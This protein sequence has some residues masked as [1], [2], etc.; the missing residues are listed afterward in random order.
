MAERSVHDEVDQIQSVGDRSPSDVPAAT[1][2]L[3]A[4]GVG[5]AENKTLEAVDNVTQEQPVTDDHAEGVE[6]LSK[7]A[8]FTNGLSG[9][10]LCTDKGN[11]DM[12]S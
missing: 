5:A 10:C 6:Q 3:L 7:V 1:N 8:S 4:T 11:S 12:R 9:V 2:N